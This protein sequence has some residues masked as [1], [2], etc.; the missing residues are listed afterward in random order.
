LRRLLR[1]CERHVKTQREGHTALPDLQT[2]PG[3]R[4]GSMK[5]E[6]AMQESRVQQARLDAAVSEQK[7]LRDKLRL[8][9]TSSPDDSRVPDTVRKRLHHLASLSADTV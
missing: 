9:G 3:G 6:Q 8:I 5:Y 4:F 7:P 1:E 2:F